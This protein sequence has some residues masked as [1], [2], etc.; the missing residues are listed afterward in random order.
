MNILGIDFGQKR[1]GLA[2][3]QVGLDVI[4]PYGVVQKKPDEIVPK[5][6]V[7][8][9]KEERINKVVI[10]LPLGMEG[11]ENMNTKRVRGFGGEL[12][13]QIDLPV[14]FMDERFTTHEASRMGGTASL[15]EKSAMLILEM[16]QELN[17]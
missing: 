6:L 15:D 4:L 11:E 7:D 3:M 14:E 2:W 9:I 8:L 13:K 1:I 12:Q 5:E 16:Y 17:K 10:G